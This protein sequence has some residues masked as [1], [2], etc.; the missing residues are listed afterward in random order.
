MFFPSRMTSPTAWLTRV[1]VGVFAAAM[2]LTSVAPA[3]ATEPTSQDEPTHESLAPRKPISAPSCPAIFM[4]DL[5]ARA[6][7][8]RTEGPHQAEAIAAARAL[9]ETML[10]L[11]REKEASVLTPPPVSRRLDFERALPGFSLVLGRLGGAKWGPGERD[12]TAARVVSAI[13]SNDV[14]VPW[15]RDFRGFVD[16]H[17]G[18]FGIR[19]DRRVRVVEDEE[20]RVRLEYPNGALSDGRVVTL[21]TYVGRGTCLPTDIPDGNEI[22]SNLPLDE[23]HLSDAPAFSAEEALR[24]FL[25]IAPYV[26]TDSEPP[27]RLVIATGRTGTSRLVWR[28]SYH[29]ECLL[30][31]A[32]VGG[33]V[34][35]RHRVAD[36][37][38]FSGS[39]L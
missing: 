12:S 3:G 33:D 16:R 35:T 10:F 27:V 31:F 18:L 32:N 25:D 30:W 4:P 21:E 15:G 13:A 37:D 20:E 17:R 26:S 23:A 9:R 14:R 29:Y 8:E 24:R 28:V 22:R 7:F 34:V 36:M 38:A 19:A 6:L 39:L 5:P 1:L 2:A 11:E